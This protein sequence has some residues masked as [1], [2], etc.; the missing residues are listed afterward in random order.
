MLLTLHP[1]NSKRY[2]G[3]SDTLLVVPQAMS[4][5]QTAFDQLKDSVTAH[6]AIVFQSTKLQDVRD[7]AFELERNLADR[8]ELRNMR[9]LEPLFLGLENYAEAADALC[10]G[11]PFLPWIWVGAR[12]R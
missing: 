3:M 10:D 8:H 5:M 2:S 1:Q 11:T 4:T 7:A 6:E 12:D 9:R